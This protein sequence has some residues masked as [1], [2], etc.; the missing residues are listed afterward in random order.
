MTI[1]QRDDLGARTPGDWLAVVREGQDW[2]FPGC[3]GQ[4]GPLCAASPLPVA[5][6]DKH[7]G[8]SGLTIVTG[9]LGPSVGTSAILAEW[10]LG[11][12]QGVALTHTRS[13]WAGTVSPFVTGLKSPVALLAGAR[14]TLFVGDWAAG[15]IYRIQRA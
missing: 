9:Q 11:K 5:V 4:G 6:L 15:T 1:D 14:G 10:A 7:A 3:Y 12:L 8:V 13:G 2:G